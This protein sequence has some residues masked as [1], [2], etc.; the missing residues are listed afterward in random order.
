[1]ELAKT[2]QP[3]YY[4]VIFS[5]IKQ[6]DAVGYDEMALKMYDLARVQPGFLG[7]ETARDELG[8]TLSYWENLES[9]QK[10]KSNSEHLE[11]QIKGKTQWYKN[12]TVRI[13]KVEH[14]YIF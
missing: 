6:N 2:P 4:T 9:I 10:W 3:P 13:A 11:A 14:D 8:L 1:M 5:S 7:F 12:Y